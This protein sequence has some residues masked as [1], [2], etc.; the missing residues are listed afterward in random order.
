ML[1]RLVNRVMWRVT[2]L[3]A[4]AGLAVL[5]SE[6]P[7]AIGHR[8]I[9]PL[10]AGSATAVE[11][12]S[13]IV[14][15]PGQV[16]VAESLGGGR[17]LK[18]PGSAVVLVV[19][20]ADGGLRALAVSADGSL[21]SWDVRDG[22]PGRTLSFRDDGFCGTAGTGD[23]SQL[24]TVCGH[25]RL[26]GW[27]TSTG[28]EIMARPITC[29]PLT[30]HPKF[31]LAVTADGS[32]AAYS[33]ACLEIQILNVADVTERALWR[34]SKDVGVSALA[35]SA[36]G[37]LLVAGHS[38]R[39][40]RANL[41]EV[42]ETATGR[43]IHRISGHGGTVLANDLS[44]DGRHI[45]STGK[46]RTLRVWDLATGRQRPVTRRLSSRDARLHGP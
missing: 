24:V 38:S 40:P 41:I 9:T 22:S 19:G 39:D 7:R 30:R 2:S 46:D 31:S 17:M 34:V 29:V 42:W 3:G 21:R 15:E 10:A 1:M 25:S 26:S 45:L 37:R 16:A 18:G 28:G 27:D 44:P 36:D 8:A 33:N 5:F 12:G 23:W 35:L 32:T 11:P 4:L 43:S 13:A 14:D 6:D 20:F